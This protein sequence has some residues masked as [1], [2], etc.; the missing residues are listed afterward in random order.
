MQKLYFLSVLLPDA[1]EDLI[2][3]FKKE[4]AARYHSVAALKPMGHITLQETFFYDDAHLPRLQRRLEEVFECTAPF[5]VELQNFGA[6]PAHTIFAAVKNFFPFQK[7][8][9]SLYWQLTHEP[10]FPSSALGSRKITPHVTIAYRD[11]TPEAFDGAWSEFC[12]R[13]LSAQFA[14][15]SAHL[16]EHRGK[17]R[18][19]R[20]FPFQNKPSRQLQSLQLDRFCA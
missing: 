14:V 19:I 20:E 2:L 8:R 17:W 11:L 13:E 1:L 18:T 15:T 10:T 12:Q 6:F 4:I 9:E 7:L 16:M 3:Q 5:A